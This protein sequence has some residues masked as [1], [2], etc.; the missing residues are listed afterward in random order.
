LLR[1]ISLPEFWV[2]LEWMN[3]EEVRALVFG[4]NGGRRS[5]NVSCV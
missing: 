5:L 1:G 4:G 3:A 2:L